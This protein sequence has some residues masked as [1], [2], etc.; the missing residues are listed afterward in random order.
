MRE[1]CSR[2]SGDAR[3]PWGVN[4]ADCA[5]GTIPK[6]AFIKACAAHN[7]GFSSA[8]SDPEKQKQVCALTASKAKRMLRDC[9]RPAEE[10]TRQATRACTAAKQ[11]QTEC[12]KY[13]SP[14]KLRPMLKRMVADACR[15]YSRKPILEQISGGNGIQSLIAAVPDAQGPAC[16]EALE[17]AG[18]RIEGFQKI[19]GDTRVY[20]IEVEADNVQSVRDAGCAEIRPNTAAMVL[21][22]G[23][24]DSYGGLDD[25]ALALQASAQDSDDAQV[26]TVLG[27]QGS[28]I[29]EIADNFKELE[30]ADKGKDAAYKI[31]QFFGLKAEQE[32]AETET[33]DAETA[34]LEETN[35]ELER[36]IAALAETNPAQAALIT[37]V[38]EEN[39]KRAETLRGLAKSK[40][41]WSAGLIS[42]L[43]G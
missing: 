28:Q 22:Q 13:S 27:Y 5:G 6:E 7:S 42:R 43:G 10:C 21:R 36:V 16:E 3:T 41:E 40:R 24:S 14:E 23:G 29:G 19:G 15:T 4:R 33:L 37:N 17:R 32:R 25:V 11:R 35:S 12:A 39:R 31:Q 2:Q 34:K 30:E 26:R 1:Q 8:L 20:F 18:A 38:L 9:N